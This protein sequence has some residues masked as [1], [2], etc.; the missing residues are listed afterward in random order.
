[1]NR[2]RTRPRDVLFAIPIFVILAITLT[3]PFVLHLADRIHDGGDPYEYAWV[4]GFGAHQLT[5]DPLHLFDGNILY[6]Y[7]LSLAYSDSTLPNVLLGTPIVLLTGNAVLALNVLTLLTFALAGL[8]MYLLVLTRTGSSVAAY[9]AGLVYG[10]SPYLF[11]HVPQLPN[12]SIEWA[13]FA[14][15]CIERFLATGRARWAS[16]F[17]LA[18]L[19]QVLVSFYYAFILGIGIGVYVAVRLVQERQVLRRPVWIAR[20]LGATAIAALVVVPLVTPY[21]TVERRFGLQRTLA[22]ADGFAAWPANY[23]SATSSLRLQAVRPLVD[24]VEARDPSLQVGAAERQL[25][26]GTFVLLLVIVGLLR[27]RWSR[28]IGPALLILLGVALSFGPTF[29]PRND[30]TVSLPFP[31]PYTLLF[32][33][34]PGFTALRVPARFGALTVLGLA[35]LAGEGLA[36]A[37]KVSSAWRTDQRWQRGLV[38]VVGAASLAV[39]ILE[40]ADQLPSEPTRVGSLV[41]PVYRWLASQP[42][43][44]PIVE[45]PIGTNGFQES[46]RAYYSTYHHQPLVN[47]SRSFLPPG[48]EA[49]VAIFATF[50]SRTAISAMATLGIRYVVVHR[51]E[52]TTTLTTILPDV[53]SGVRRVAQFGADDVYEVTAS[54]EP[55]P[56]RLVA[57]APCLS[58]AAGPGAL[59][60]TIEPL[61][62]RTVLLLSPRTTDL[63]FQLVWHGRDGSSEEEVVRVPVASPIIELPDVVSL[64]YRQPTIANVTSVSISLLGG[65]R[66]VATSATVAVTNVSAP[67]SATDAI[68]TLTLARLASSRGRAA[69]GIPFD[70][71]WRHDVVPA[72]RL[73]AFVN[74]YDD[75]ARY[76]TEPLDQ[77]EQFLTPAWCLGGETVETQRLR[78]V[79]GTPPGAYH[80]EVGLMNVLT[81]DRVP[82]VGPDQNTVTKVDL[83]VYRVLP[84]NVIANG[85]T[86]GSGAERLVFADALALDHAAIL[87]PTSGAELPVYLRWSSLRTVS[88]NYTMFL[89]VSDPNGH[90]V[91]QVDHP[92]GGTTFPTTAWRPGDLLLDEENVTL[93]PQLPPGPLSIS[94]GVYDL[95][96]LR[97]LP[98]TSVGDA[99]GIDDVKIGTIGS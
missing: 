51:D 55:P 88:T 97:R 83:G 82:F 53:A 65:D 63:A 16:G 84:D 67:A 78:F 6:P 43:P 50:P 87:G 58:T 25:Y 57:A 61:D 86:S 40:S 79:P 69:D 90:V 42:E 37:L 30:V 21:F 59:S 10:F 19:L 39:L 71:H 29:H 89:H 2:P 17:A 48:Y 66:L 56:L 62:D 26:P 85:A 91:A 22:D 31:M 20:L 9:G 4:L 11:D 52:L 60:L 12:I 27:A 38:A 77:A 44:S 68:P 96:T 36:A 49:M 75:Q 92:L 94:V 80:V 15:W 73:V 24:L 13:P 70:L 95:A 28:W 35:L 98:I 64:A 34:V 7:P 99:S 47:G 3:Y 46:P 54:G 14:L 23:L 8:G 18:T 1:V 5:R 72:N 45:L 41:P 81:G 76:W 32:D 74:A 93:P 33:Y